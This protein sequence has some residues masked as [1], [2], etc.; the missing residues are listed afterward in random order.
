MSGEAESRVAIIVP[1]AQQALAEA[2]AATGKPVIVLLKHGRA[3]AL[4][5]AVKDAPAILACW[6]LGSETGNA[7]ADVLFGVVNP[8]A[9][10]SVSFPHYSGQE[11]YFYDHRPTGRPAPATGDQAY[12][13]RYRETKNEALYPFGHGLTYSDIVLSELRLPTALA[14]DGTLE[15]SALITNRGRVAGTEVVQLYIR[16]PVASRTRPI[17]Q[18][19]GFE[20]VALAPGESRRVSFMLKRAD[21]LFWGDRGWTV[22][23]GKFDLWV[24]T[25]S[26]NGLPGTFELTAA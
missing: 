14:W 17:R 5:G 4:S 13:A 18:L 6:F 20:R 21:L 11:P 16:D 12:K 25:S 26:T 10:L 8:S 9:K 7:V 15:A 23:P 22:E 2:V 24:A 1:E 3:L 19:K